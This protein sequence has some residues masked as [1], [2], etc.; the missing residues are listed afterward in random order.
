MLTLRDRRLGHE[1]E[2]L[3]QLRA[4]WPEKLLTLERK[5]DEAFLLTVADMPA[6]SARPEKDLFAVVTDLHSITISF[7]RYYP[8]MPCEIYLSRPVFHPNID[9]V[10]GF[11]CLWSRHRVTNTS[12]QALIQLRAIL[13]WRLFNPDA[14]HLMQPDALDWHNN[15]LEARTYLPL[16]NGPWLETALVPEHYQQSRRRRLS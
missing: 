1:W 4:N 12:I 3:W 6:L 5:G 16:A 9:P 11:V 13:A 15:S 10:T 14:P 8:S 2:V 7:P